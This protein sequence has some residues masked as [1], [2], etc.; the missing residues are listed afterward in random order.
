[1]HLFLSDR[2]SLKF[3]DSDL[4]DAAV[5]GAE[6]TGLRPA[7]C[8]H[9]LRFSTIFHPLGR[10]GS[11]ILVDFWAKATEEKLEAARYRRYRNSSDS[12]VCLCNWGKRN[13]EKY[14]KSITVHLSQCHLKLLFLAD[15][16]PFW[17]GNRQI[18]TTS[19]SEPLG[20]RWGLHGIFTFP[21]YHLCGMPDWEAIWN[22]RACKYLFMISIILGF[23]CR[24]VKKL[25]NGKFHGCRFWILES[26]T[27]L[28]S[29]VILQVPFD[30]KFA[31]TSSL[32]NQSLSKAWA[33]W[34]GNQPIWCGNDMNRM[35]SSGTHLVIFSHETLLL[36]FFVCQAG[37][38]WVK[39]ALWFF[40]DVPVDELHH[41]PVILRR[42]SY[43]FCIVLSHRRICS[44]RRSR[45]FESVACSSYAVLHSLTSYTKVF[46][47]H[48]TA[49]V[50]HHCA[51]CLG[52][53]QYLISVSKDILRQKQARYWLWN[54]GCIDCIDG[55]S[56]YS[57]L[58]CL[59]ALLGL[60]GF[61][62]NALSCFGSIWQ[63]LY[64]IDS[65]RCKS[66]FFWMFAQI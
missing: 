45:L 16:T 37:E 22:I 28:L 42:P 15:K 54:F 24:N 27:H 10:L 33:A 40:S 38:T 36:W 6:K 30:H 66:C 19:W 57:L 13:G 8:G 9:G 51:A 48:Q 60:L 3:Q 63:T 52:S 4:S 56:V 59:L 44:V 31:Y 25:L 2:N 5:G 12:H 35:S 41:E 26:L 34:L 62:V 64:L 7:S 49:D 29:Q 53:K 58:H 11:S 65:D 21:S 55:L 17:H 43:L 39:R 14:R 23:E 61:D 18:S 46:V 20:N 1:M 50:A 32:K 47:S